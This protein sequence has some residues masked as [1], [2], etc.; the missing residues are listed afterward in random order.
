MIHIVRTTSVNVDGP[1]R[2]HVCWNELCRLL[3]AT[4]R[5]D[6]IANKRHLACV[7]IDIGNLRPVEPVP[8]ELKEVLKPAEVQKPPGHVV[9]GEDQ[10]RGYLLL[11]TGT[12]VNRRRRLVIGIKDPITLLD[13]LDSLDCRIVPVSQF[14]SQH[15]ANTG[16]KR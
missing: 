3:R 1:S 15:G 7:W 13:N 16:E 5:N 8:V 2:T 6:W 11:N 10:I 4:Q 12:D 9:G 14:L